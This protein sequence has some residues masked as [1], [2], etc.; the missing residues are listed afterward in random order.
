ME[1]LRTPAER[2]GP[3]NLAVVRDQM[4]ESGWVR[5]GVN[6]Q[7]GR[8]RRVW[9][10]DASTELVPV[11]TYEALRTLEGLR[12]GKTP[13][14]E[15]E[16]VKA[17]SVDHVDA[18]LPHVSRQVAA[19]IIL[20]LKSGA[21]GGELFRLRPMDFDMSDDVW[22]A[23]LVEHKTAHRGKSRTLCF[24]PTAQATIRPF[25]DRAID[26]YLFSPADA[27]AERL[28]KR[29]AARKTPANQG[30]APGTNKKDNPTLQPG[31]CYNKD[32]YARAVA[33][34]CKRAGVPRWTPHQLRHRAATEIR[35]THGVDASRTILGH[36]TLD[37]TAIY[38]EADM[39]KAREV[40]AKIG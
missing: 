40:S 22:T 26:A 17:V 6:E 34:A 33:R 12:Q 31:D 38:A 19:L 3:R 32:S 20:Q 13:A 14:P 1:V 8:V 4:I 39:Q 30:N 16:P 18:V 15:S 23:N 27:E 5:R 29:H 9:K 35:R 24:G 36:S 25:L 7:V 11:A 2:F 21:Q 28:A 10:W 37:A